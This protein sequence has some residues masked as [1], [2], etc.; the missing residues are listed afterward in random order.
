MYGIPTTR[1]LSLLQGRRLAKAHSMP[2]S[3]QTLFPKRTQ[4]KPSKAKSVDAYDAQNREAARRI[5]ASE[6]A[7][8]VLG[9]WARAVL[10]AQSVK[11]TC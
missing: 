9:E 1:K 6:A 2:R 10:K 8:G 3:Q 5:L 7:D 4:Q 11:P